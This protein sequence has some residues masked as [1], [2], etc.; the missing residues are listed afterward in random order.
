MSDVAKAMDCPSAGEREIV[1]VYLR[2]GLPEREARAFEEHYFQC[3]R[4]AEAVE[5]GSKLR[6]AF[7]KSPV[8]PVAPESRGLA[9]WLPLAAAA[10]IAVVGYS[11]WQTTARQ[12]AGPSVLRAVHPELDVKVVRSPQGGFEITWAPPPTAATY[13]LEIFGADGTSL[14]KGESREPRVSIARDA[15][16]GSGARAMIQVEAFDAMHQ[17]VAKSSPSLLEPSEERP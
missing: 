17:T 13:E 10:V 12:E 9:T 6:E 11:V 15:L 7:G 3:E 8:V 5:V 14:W 4:C 2:G 16:P 1:S